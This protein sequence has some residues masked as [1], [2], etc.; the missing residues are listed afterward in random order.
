MCVQFIALSN[1]TIVL[2]MNRYNRNTD[3]KFT[4]YVSKIFTLTSKGSKFS[5][6]TIQIP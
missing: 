4:S 6:M 5:C 1:I 2:Q 3:Y